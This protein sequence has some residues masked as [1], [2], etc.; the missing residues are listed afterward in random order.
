MTYLEA[1]IKESLRLYPP[2]PM[3]ARKISQDL[4]LGD[5]TAPSGCS[6]YLSILALHKDPKIFSEPL[7]FRPERFLDHRR[8]SPFV[9][10]P[11]SAGA[12]SCIGQKFAM[13][14][15]KV[16]LTK[17]LL[18]YNIRSLEDRSDI[19]MTNVIVSRPLNG[20]RIELTNRS[21]R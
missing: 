9:F 6:L 16:I 1:I 13:N 8:E 21:H 2:V 10:T 7:L 17:V 11:F 20:I 15:L 14:E 18:N 12:R 3:I 5:Y 4:K 19:V